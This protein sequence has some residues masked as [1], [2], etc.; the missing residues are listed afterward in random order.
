MSPGMRG[1]RVSSIRM[2]TVKPYWLKPPRTRP[3]VILNAASAIQLDEIFLDAARVRRVGLQREVFL[4]RVLGLSRVL[5]LVVE[6]AE[7][8]ERIRVFRVELGR[9]LVA[10]QRHLHEPRLVGDAAGALCLQPVKIAV[11]DLRDRILRRESQHAI[12]LL[13]R[14][15]EPA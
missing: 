7:L 5:L 3:D 1:K 14:E 6:E 2:P 8:A 11:V 12:E 4:E 9:P 10:G 15:G 13:L